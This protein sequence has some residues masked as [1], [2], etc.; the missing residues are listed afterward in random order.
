MREF[1]LNSIANVPGVLTFAAPQA[2]KNNW[3][4]RIGLAYSPGTNGKT[5]IRSGFGIAYDQIFDNVGTNTRPPQATSTVDVT[6]GVAGVPNANFLKNGGILP[7]R[8]TPRSDRR[9]GSL[10]HFGVPS[11]QSTTGLRAHLELWRS[12]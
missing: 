11:G 6:N 9:Y 7:K 1:A 8:V 12:A 10:E 3:A 5:S 4:P 2:A